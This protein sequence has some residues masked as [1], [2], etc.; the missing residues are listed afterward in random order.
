MVVSILRRETALGGV[1]VDLVLWRVH[2]L[3]LE[4]FSSAT[5]Y[6]RVSHSI[7]QAMSVF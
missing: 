7:L 6:Y 1:V 5:P 4:P 2:W 3:L